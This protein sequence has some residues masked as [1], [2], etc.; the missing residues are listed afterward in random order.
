MVKFIKKGPAIINKIYQQ[1]EQKIS[2]SQRQIELASIWFDFFCWYSTVQN[3]FSWHKE[4]VL[5]EGTV[6]SVAAVECWRCGGMRRGRNS[7]PHKLSARFSILNISDL[8]P[9]K[10]TDTA[11]IN[12]YGPANNQQFYPGEHS[13]E[14]RTY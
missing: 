4:I 6:G 3:W 8:P 7:P 12:Y 9:F 11:T 14:M 13:T 5:C 10:V 1:N 2:L